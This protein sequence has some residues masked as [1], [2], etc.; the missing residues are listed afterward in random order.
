MGI[1]L[2]GKCALITG[3]SAGLGA[4]IVQKL[5][6]E[7]CHVAINY[8]NSK[9]RAVELAKKI[10]SEHGVNAIHL[11]ANVAEADSCKSL[12]KE[13]VEQL[14]GLD[15]VI[16][17]AGW[18]RAVDFADIDALTEED[19]DKCY[20]MNVKSH[21]HLFRAAKP[22]FDKNEDGGAF[23]ITGSAAGLKPSGSSIPYSLTKAT[24]VHLVKC[25]AKTQ[26]PKARVNI[27]C[28]GLLL[29]EWGNSFGPEK[30]KKMENL[31]PLKH[32]SYID[33]TA[34]VFISTA[35]NTSQTG[36]VI[37]VDSGLSVV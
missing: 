29:T 10:T 6:G 34:D 17:N 4:A 2:K 22:H 36:S 11:Q 1:S 26:G 23:L 35:K 27:V 18:T 31:A 30:I 8:S 37:S 33:D 20:A 16:S 13:T 24:S 14:G 21:F 5:A 3:G 19:F 7:G 28:P 15:V 12:I 25:L 9:E 32:T